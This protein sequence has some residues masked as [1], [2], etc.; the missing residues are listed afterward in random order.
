MEGL[1]SPLMLASVPRWRR[2]SPRHW[3]TCAHI[4]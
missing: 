1:E 3:P 2:R 4:N